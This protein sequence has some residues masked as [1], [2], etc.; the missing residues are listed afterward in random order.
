MDGCKSNSFG[1]SDREQD[2]GMIRRMFRCICRTQIT[3]TEAESVNV[4][5]WAWHVGKTYSLGTTAADVRQA[6]PVKTPKYALP[7]ILA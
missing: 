6:M 4:H 2:D 3:A 7:R 1:L 5:G